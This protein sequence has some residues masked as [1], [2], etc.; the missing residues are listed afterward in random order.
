M[1]REIPSQRE[2]STAHASPTP[3]QGADKAACRQTKARR[4]AERFEWQFASSQQEHGVSL[5]CKPAANRDGGLQQN[6]RS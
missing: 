3:T 6:M 5:R 1:E 2:R 4:T